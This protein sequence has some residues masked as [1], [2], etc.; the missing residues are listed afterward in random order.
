MMDAP[1]QS[2]L[3]KQ[4]IEKYVWGTYSPQQVQSLA[5]AAVQ[6]LQ[7]ANASFHYPDLERL[8]RLGTSGQYPSRCNSEL[9]AFLEPS[10]KLC[11]AY[12]AT[13]PFKAPLLD[14]QQDML[15]PHE[16]FSSMF[17]QYP[18]AFEN[19]LLNSEAELERFWEAARNHPQY[20]GH[21][22][23]DRDTFQRKCVPIGIHG[24][25]VPITGIGKGWTSK[26]TIFSW[27]SMT[28]LGRS[29]KDKM[30]L[31][32]ACFEK[33]RVRQEDRN[34][35]H[36]FFR[37]LAWSLWWLWLGVFPDTDVDG[38]K[39]FAAEIRHLGKALYVVWLKFQK[40]DLQIHRDI[41]LVLKLNCAMETL[42]EDYRT[43]YSFPPEAARRFQ[44][45]CDGMLLML[46]KV[47]KHYAEV[48][49]KICRKYR[50]ALHLRFVE[51]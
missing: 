10:V 40:K 48:M 26:M 43:E 20:Q 49:K 32:Y 33:L 6:D 50:I 28:A 38:N 27:Y 45:A 8:A 44:S 36:R 21:P 1:E 3:A 15:L 7:H 9:L 47:A 2:A 11:P 14:K 18:E 17:H 4:L 24:D 12:T 30:H 19:N 51:L 29:T 22:I 23:S 13:V 35:L 25:D 16:V 46:S 37:V 42:I 31:I 34:T 41:A 5:F 39:S